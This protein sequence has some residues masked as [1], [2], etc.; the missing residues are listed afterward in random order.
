MA[1]LRQ[2]FQEGTISDAPLLIGATTMNS[3]ELA[4]LVAVTGSDVLAITLDPDGDD[5]A[6]EIIH[7]TAHTASATSATIARGQEGTAAREH[8]AGTVWE[9]NITEDDFDYDNLQDL[10]AIGYPKSMTEI[11]AGTTTYTTPSGITVIRVCCIGPGGGGGGAATAGSSAAGGAGGGGGGYAEVLILNPAAS[12]ACVVGAGGAGGAAGNNAGSNGS[13]STTF[14]SPSVCTATAGSGG[15]GMAAGTSLTRNGAGAP[16]EGTVGS[17][18][19]R[20]GAGTAGVRL[21]GVEVLP[22]FGGAAA[23]GGGL[24]KDS[25]SG[26]TTGV[27]GANWGGGGSG[28]LVTNGSA[29]SAGGAGANGR[30]LVY[31]FG[32]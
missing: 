19:L 8:A 7:V 31:E 15:S 14:D 12:Y 10:P 28:G 17:V 29:A 11:A 18:L 32:S 2:N 22:G 24:T 16:G 26:G 6:P 5:G 25:G 20:G 4:G 3:A 1:R 13:A 27:A 30:I 23:R 21:T 9:H